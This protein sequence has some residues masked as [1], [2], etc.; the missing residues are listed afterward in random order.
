MFRLSAA[1]AVLGAVLPTGVGANGTCQ[2][3]DEVSLRVTSTGGSRF[4]LFDHD[5]ARP[6][7]GA[8]TGPED[9]LCVKA[10]TCTKLNVFA[11]DASS[12]T[13]SDGKG[14]AKE[15]QHHECYFHV[16]A[17]D[18]GVSSLS[19]RTL[20]SVV[21]HPMMSEEEDFELPTLKH[22]SEKKAR[23]GADAEG[24]GGQERMRKMFEQVRN[25][26][27]VQY[28]YDFDTNCVSSGALCGEDGHCP[29]D[30]FCYIPTTRKK[31]RNLAGE[32]V[33]DEADHGRKMKFGSNV[34]GTCL[35]T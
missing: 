17:S 24:E 21:E 34:G 10:A 29:P 13:V 35:C 27:G 16:C 33:E 12:V 15:C 2:R 23:G 14:Q 26:Q 19:V 5:D 8:L 20:D 28:S 7:V 1:I 22:A 3:R 11:A 25:L 32:E 9:S 30:E 31:R 18:S 4:E 6:T